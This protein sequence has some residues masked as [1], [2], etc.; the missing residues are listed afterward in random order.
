M[1]SAE[2]MFSRVKLVAKNGSDKEKEELTCFHLNSVFFLLGCH[3]PSQIG[4][5]RLECLGGSCGEGIL[6]RLSVFW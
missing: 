4:E 3:A 5:K 6:P 2:G 1:I